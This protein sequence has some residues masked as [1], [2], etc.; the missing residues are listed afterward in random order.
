MCDKKTLIIGPLSFIVAMTIAVP[1]ATFLDAALTDAQR[2][3]VIADPLKIE[4][5]QGSGT[6]GADNSRRTNFGFP[7]DHTEPIKFLSKPKALYTDLARKKDVQGTVRLKVVLL[8]SGTVGAITPVTTLP[9]G[10][11]EQ[12][13]DAARQI[14]FTPKV[15]EGRPTSIVVTVDYDFRLF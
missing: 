3:V 2:T 5:G 10:L 9:Y 15:V 7:Y 8:A 13:V 6:S 14:K 12:A 11:T 1:V 4:P